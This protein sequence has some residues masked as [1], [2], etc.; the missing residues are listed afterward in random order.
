MTYS[1][2]DILDT[3]KQIIENEHDGF[4]KENIPDNANFYTDLSFDSLDTFELIMKLEQI[5]N[6]EFGD[7]FDDFRKEQTIDALAG[8]IYMHFH[9]EIFAIKTK[10]DVFK[11]VNKRLQNKYGILNAQPKDNFFID[12][13]F[14]DIHRSELIQW[15]D[16]TFNIRLQ[17]TYF[18]NLDDFCEKVFYTIQRQIK[19]VE[20]KTKA[21][22]A[23]KPVSL[24]PRIAQRFKGRFK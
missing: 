3:I 10:E 21:P 19:K 20:E 6:T 16:E 18:I 2:P 11:F 24:L 15:A 12:L 22:Q 1:K 4:Q 13:H 8:S 17:H 9:P 14:N 7:K 5:Y 23:Q